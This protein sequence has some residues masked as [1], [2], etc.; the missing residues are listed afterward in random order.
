[1]NKCIVK[2]VLTVGLWCL[3]GQYAVSSLSKF[4]PNHVCFHVADPGRSPIKIT[5]RV[6]MAD[7]L[8]SEI[9]YYA[10]SHVNSP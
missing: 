3:A 9:I 1:M 7:I 10:A 6:L 2:L 4:D 5:Y 8:V